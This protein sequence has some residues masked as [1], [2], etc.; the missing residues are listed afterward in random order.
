MLLYTAKPCLVLSFEC[1]NQKLSKE[2]ILV[3]PKNF[4][5]SLAIF[6]LFSKSRFLKLIANSGILYKKLFPFL[7]IVKLEILFAISK[8]PL[9][10][11]EKNCS[12]KRVKLFLYLFFYLVFQVVILIY[13]IRGT[14]MFNIIKLKVILKVENIFQLIIQF[15]RE[16]YLLPIR[17]LNQGKII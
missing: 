13:I 15:L 9:T 4:L 11:F 1:S 2:I 6:K 17:Y 3:K 8:L 5:F 12:S 7:N 10:K 14:L 16:M